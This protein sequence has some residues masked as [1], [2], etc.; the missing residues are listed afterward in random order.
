MFILFSKKHITG[1]VHDVMTPDDVE[2]IEMEL[3][4]CFMSNY[5]G[6]GLGELF[7]FFFDSSIQAIC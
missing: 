3:Y 5:F 2:D 4:K 1:V 7:L 6:I